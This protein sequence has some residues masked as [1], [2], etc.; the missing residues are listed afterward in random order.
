MSV[1]CGTLAH[2]AAFR[3][4]NL[5]A[6]SSNGKQHTLPP[7]PSHSKVSTDSIEAS[8]SGSQPR[9]PSRLW[10]STKSTR[11]GGLE[12]ADCSPE[13]WSRGEYWNVDSNINVWGE[14]EVRRNTAESSHDVHR[15]D[16]IR[17]VALPPHPDA[18][19]QEPR[20]CI[21]GVVTADS[22][23]LEA[24]GFDLGLRDRQANPTTLWRPPSK[25]EMF[26][27]LRSFDRNISRIAERTRSLRR[28]ASLP[29]E[30]AT[31]SSTIVLED[32][33]GELDELEPSSEQLLTQ[34]KTHGSRSCHYWDRWDHTA[35][36]EAAKA[37]ISVHTPSMTWHPQG[38]VV[39]DGLELSPASVYCLKFRKS[40]ENSFRKHV[41][42]TEKT[43]LM[44]SGEGSAM[45]QTVRVA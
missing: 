31:T 36:R 26:R 1:G 24:W 40:G 21:S 2:P 30:K 17:R 20:Q 16:Q 37:A 5:A 14:H 9:G 44:A 18:P 23:F 41:T 33:G 27:S 22:C 42:S 7:N 34:G 45:V 3:T 11:F 12:N 10:G 25:G 8:F 38:W 35:K 4:G 6:S 29:G 39:K 15:H 19:K 32:L 43:S 28:S 13:F